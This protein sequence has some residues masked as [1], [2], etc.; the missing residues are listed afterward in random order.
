MARNGKGTCDSTRF[1]VIF[2]QT[3]YLS[4][5]LP[6]PVVSG[7]FELKPASLLCPWDFPG[8]NTGMGCYFR[9]Q[10]LFL[11][12]G[13]NLHLLRWQAGSLPLSHL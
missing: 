8:K 6:L 1:S 10:G 3:P 13:S 12:Q 7:S 9:F 5:P 4:P 2:N 11:T